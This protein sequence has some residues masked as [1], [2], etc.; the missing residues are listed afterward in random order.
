MLLRSANGW[1]AAPFKRHPGE[2]RM[3]LNQPTVVPS[4]D[5]IAIVAAIAIAPQKVTRTT[6]RNIGALPARAPSAPRMARKTSDA[7]ETVHGSVSP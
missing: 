1:S 7:A 2:G 3:V 6:A 5:P 4:S